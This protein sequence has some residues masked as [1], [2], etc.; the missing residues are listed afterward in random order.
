MAS[1]KVLKKRYARAI[2]EGDYYGAEQ[3]CRTLYHRLTR[4]RG[5][6]LSDDDLNAAL[7]H[8]SSGAIELLQKGQTQAGSALGLLAIKHMSE[9]DV[10]VS[11]SSLS[12]VR[13]IHSAY[14]NGSGSDESSLAEERKEKLRLLAAAVKWSSRPS[15][16]GTQYG[17]PQLNAWAGAAAHA[18][19]EF[20]TAQRYFI[21]SNAPTMFAAALQDWVREAGLESEHGIFLARAAL[22]YLCAENIADAGALR[23]EYA[24]RMGWPDRPKPK[25]V[26]PLANFVELIIKASQ[27]G[28]QAKA[29]FHRIGEVYRPALQA[30]KELV[31]LLERVGELYFGIRPAQPSGMAGMMQSML[32]GMMSGANA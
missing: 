23:S 24:K 8:A 14:G 4:P 13:D 27:L 21:R 22:L 29:L 1:V 7:T 10:A 11:D 18:A 6:E 32:Q 28:P 3:A 12:I 15:C 16:Q 25:E 31:T 20:E 19:G 5:E 26:P 17:D 9:H 2:E 30:D